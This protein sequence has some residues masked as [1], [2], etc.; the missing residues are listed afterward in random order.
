MKNM[1]E[2]EQAI[3]RK[4]ETF[5]SC[6]ICALLDDYEFEMLSHLQYD[7]TIDAQSRKTVA[8][9]MGFCEFHFRQFRKIANSKTNALLLLDLIEQYSQTEKR[10]EIRCRFCNALRI[11]EES[12]LDT[13][14]TML[15]QGSFRQIYSKSSGVCLPHMDVIL[16]RVCS[17]DLKTW[18]ANIQ[19][20]QMR[21]EI[22]ALTEMAR[23][24]Y[25][26]LSKHTRGS[27]PRMVQKL[28]GRRALSL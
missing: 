3:H 24:S 12:L 1:T 18:L 11:Q 15:S 14:S 4:I 6:P 9:E 13:I 7:I 23:L 2:F 20:E 10:L 21:R 8:S 19:G 5:A 26:D 25:Y 28:V 22:T 17:N 16:Q 27:V